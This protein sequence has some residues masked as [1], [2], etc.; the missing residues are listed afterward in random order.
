MFAAEVPAPPL[1][2]IGRGGGADI[3]TL[4]FTQNKTNIKSHDFT[5][6]G[7]AGAHL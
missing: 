1:V 7:Q 5:K 6:L 2:E 3:A 4:I